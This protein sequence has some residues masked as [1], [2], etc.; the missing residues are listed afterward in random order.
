MQKRYRIKTY[1]RK[2]KLVFHFVRMKNLAQISGKQRR[3][4]GDDND[5]DLDLDQV[6]RTGESEWRWYI[7]RSENTFP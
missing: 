1:W 2:A 3:Q 4:G 5:N 7:I 6:N